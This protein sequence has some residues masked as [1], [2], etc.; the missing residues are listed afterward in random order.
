M[1][2]KAKDGKIKLKFPGKGGQK[3]QKE[4]NTKDSML[5]AF[6]Q[7]NDDDD[8]CWNLE[9]YNKFA[10]EGGNEG[11]VWLMFGEIKVFHKTNKQEK[12]WFSTV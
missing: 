8:E 1:L 11:S 5:G 10:D 4:N 12:P 3:L 9:P 7:Q 2:G 6:C